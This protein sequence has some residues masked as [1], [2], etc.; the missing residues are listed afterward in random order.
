M[1]VAIT[2]ASGHLGRATADRLLQLVD[3]GQVVLVT[4][5]PEQLDEYARRGASVRRGDFDDPAPLCEAFAGVDSVLVISTDAIG[6]R[7]AQHVAAIE[8]ATAAGVRRV[9][10]TSILNPSEENPAAVCGEHRAT[11]E[12]I[13]ASG[14]EWTI[15]RNGIY[16][17]FQ[18]PSVQQ[19]IATGRHVHNG[20]DGVIAYVAREDCAAVAAAVLAGEGHEGKIYDVTGPELLS[21]SDVAALAAAAGGVPVEAVAVDDETRVAGLVENAGL[22][23]PVARFAASFGQAVREGQLA[24]LTTVVEDVAGRAPRSLRDLVAASAADVAAE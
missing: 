22:P 5:H 6:R 24:Q 9:A 2:G 14:L 10:Y 21:G 18:L 13:F 1:S 20:G 8:A 11:E 3:P 4:R 19:A 23:E 17:D 16:A 15:L 12:A 7:V